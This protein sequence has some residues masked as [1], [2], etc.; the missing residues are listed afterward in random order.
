MSSRLR[1]IILLTLSGVL[2]AL[3]FS[4]LSATPLIFIAFLPLLFLQD[5][6]LNTNKGSSFF[7]EA[8][9]IAPAFLIF[10]VLGFWWVKNAAWIGLVVGALY[11]SI[12]M[13][14]ALTVRFWFSQNGWRKLGN[15]AFISAW[16]SMEYLFLNYFEL[17]F[18]WLALGNAFA[19]FPAWIQWYEYTGVLGGTLWVLLVNVVL[20][21]YLFNS[22]Q[23]KTKR[24]IP[25]R[26]YWVVGAILIPLIYSYLLYAKY[27]ETA[28]E[29]EVAILQPNIDPYGDKWEI[30]KFHQQMTR[31]VDRSLSVLDSNTSFLLWPETSIPGY[32]YFEQENWQ[33][34]ELRRIMS[35]YPSLHL[36]LGTSAVRSYGPD[37]VASTTYRT[38]GAGNK[39][40]IYN[41]A[42]F[43]SPNSVREEY[44]KSKLVMGVE[45]VP[46]I[47]GVPW[48]KKLV[49]DLGGASG[50]LGYQEE[51]EVF[52]G[53]DSLGIAPVIC[54]ESI[55]GNY[56]TEYIRK[57]ANI[58]GIIT[59]DG[60]WGDTPGYKQHFDYARLRAIENRR[61]VV[62]SANTGISGAINQKGDILKKSEYWEPDQFTVKVRPGNNITFYSRHGDFLGRVAFVTLV[63]LVLISF[64]QN[65]IKAS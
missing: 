39:Y 29:V 33:E 5:Q 60:W 14:L 45:K 17:D 59:N 4:P 40:D 49:V 44:Y 6:R 65:R 1:Y 25:A 31:F 8:G 21:E 41:A 11:N 16:L 52:F 56:C 23:P 48:L 47:S 32:I 20:Y 54:Y 37:D 63:L 43:Y 55:F 57:G 62:R 15:T 2:L 18:I 53:K 36:L 10:C 13:G 51:R 12:V 24:S 64:V 34:N 50:Q 28:E 26:R 35:R 58:I 19:E 3:S 27:D 61:P 7:R 42:L 22:N 9:M 46:F 38:D 30:R